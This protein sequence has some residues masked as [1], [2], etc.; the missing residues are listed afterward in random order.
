MVVLVI[1]GARS[2]KSCWAE[3]L[4]VATGLGPIYLATAGTAGTAAPVSADAEFAARIAAHR[5][6][7]GP[8]WQTVEEETGIAA[9]IAAQPANKVV[10]V[11]C[12]TLWL[13]NLM[14]RAQDVEAQTEALLAALATTPARVILVSNEVGA[15]LVPATP[16]GR[17]FRD[18]QGVLN[19]Q[20]AAAASDVVTL[21]AGLPLYLKKNGKILHG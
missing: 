2:G 10:L 1:G 14:A 21:I 3:K 15:G 16:L 12:L 11:D 4:A 17:A 13:S 6:R 7:R 8:G 20:V 18:A 19:Q 5:A 9:L